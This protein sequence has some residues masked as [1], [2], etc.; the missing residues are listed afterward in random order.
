MKIIIMNI[1]QTAFFLRRNFPLLFFLIAVFCIEVK[2]SNLS[3]EKILLKLDSTSVNGQTSPN[4]N[5]SDQSIIFVLSSSD[6]ISVAFISK[7][8]SRTDIP[9]FIYDTPLGLDTT[10]QITGGNEDLLKLAV[11]KKVGKAGSKNLFRIITGPILNNMQEEKAYI[12]ITGENPEQI[13]NPRQIQGFLSGAAQKSSISSK[14]RMPGSEKINLNYTKNRVKIY[15]RK[16]GLYA[17]SG[18]DLEDKGWD[19]SRINRNYLRLYNLGREIPIEIIGSKKRGLQR[20]DK[21]VFFGEKLSDIDVTHYR[22]LT[23]YS[24]ENVYILELSDSPG[25]R[26]SQEEGMIKSSSGEPFSYPFTKKVYDKNSLI[27]LRNANFAKPEEHLVYSGAIN[28]GEK[29]ESSVTL[30]DPDIWST[31]YVKFKMMVRGD[32]VN[33]EEANPVDVYLGGRL[34]ASGEWTGANLSIIQSSDFSP[35][36]LDEEGK[37]SI[38]VI[39]RSSG[40]EFSPMYVD[41]FEITYPRLFKADENFLRFRAPEKYSGAFCNFTIENFSSPDIILFKKDISRIIGG[42]VKSVTDSLN[43]K[44]FTLSFEDSIVSPD[45]EYLA[46]TVRSLLMPDSIN[47]IQFPASFLANN[48]APNIIIVPVDSFLTDINRLVKYRDENGIKSAVVMLDD[49]YN[50]FG[51][52]IPGPEPIRL[53]LRWAYNV[54]NPKPVTVLL[55]GSGTFWGRKSQSEGNLIPVPIFH[56]IKFGACAADHFYSLLEGGDNKPDLGVAR[57]PVKTIENLKTIVDKTI[58]YGNVPAQQ[59]Q[60]SYCFIAA[61]GHGNIFLYQTEEFISKDISPDLS[62]VRLYLSSAKGASYVGTRDNLVSYINNG[63]FLLN[64]RGHGG[65]AVWSDG[66]TFVIEDMDLLHNKG[67]YPFVTSMTCFTAD[68]SSTREGLGE[69][70]LVSK[71]KGAVGFWGATGVGWI[72]NDYNLLTEF[73][74]VMRTEPDMYV[75]E[76]IKE[77]KRNFL[78]LYGGSIARSDAYQYTLLGDPCLKLAFP[79]EYADA[80]LEK[81]AV[82]D[83]VIIKGNSTGS[84][85]NVNIE[86][87][88]SDLQPVYKTDFTFMSNKWKTA[89]PVPDTLKSASE[90][91]GVRIWEKNAQ[92]D[93]GKHKYIPFSLSESYFDSL[94]TDP[95]I[96]NPGFKFRISIL[97]DSEE[98]IDSMWCRIT[99]P[100][101]DISLMQRTNSRRFVTDK[102]FGPYEPDSDIILNFYYVTDQK[103]KTESDVYKIHIPGMPDL[104]CRRVE[105]TG[106]DEVLLSAFIANTGASGVDSLVVK[107]ICPDLSFTSFDTISI[108]KDSFET[109][110]V[111]F[112]PVPGNLNISITVDPESEIGETNEENNNSDFKLIPSI[113]NV[114]NKSGTISGSVKDTVGVEGIGYCF[115]PP[116]SGIE[117]WCVRISKSTDPVLYQQNG[118]D[119]KFTKDTQC[120]GTVILPVSDD[121]KKPALYRW[122]EASKRWIICSGVVKKTKV[123]ATV[124]MP[125]S[126]S[127]REQSDD[128]PPGIEIQVQG[129][130][131]ASGS[132]VAENPT[133]TILVEDSSGVNI[134]PDKINIYLDDI[135]AN[136]S[137]IVIPD[138]VKNPRSL[139]VLYRPCLEDGEHYLVVTA[140]DVNG[141]EKKTEPVEL[142]VSSRFEIKYL[143]NHPNPFSPFKE[144]TIFAYILTGPAEKVSLKIFTVSG[145]LVKEFDDYL[146]HGADYH[147]IEW[148]G[149][150]MAGEKVANGVYFFSIEAESDK[151][152][153]VVR[154]K[155]AIIQ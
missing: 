30:P 68:F 111:P 141:N 72:F 142:L 32:A 20:D 90:T 12:E 115:I 45:A 75:G 146:M 23:M 152:K 136:K 101:A 51:Y 2:A 25:L 79:S 74:R 27:R 126:F 150:D 113:F 147:E 29:W 62:P 108:G 99:N 11:V 28:G 8:G 135:P 109:A 95:L 38:T 16:E 14:S 50:E 34:I 130:P 22:P 39:N 88:G 17:V 122:S 114:T 15:I 63:L 42:V 119:I 44:T 134:N 35:A 37:N 96:V 83:S 125:G 33:Q 43:N 106:T 84:Q 41:W 148:D 129:Q 73:L 105:L 155:I 53:F 92:S 58:E 124:S 153:E 7:S 117:N 9:A 97:A 107:F 24:L 85:S 71:D 13:I 154:G 110:E 112:S 131:F 94:E 47:S 133:I 69:S 91:G 81:R 54:W 104:S 26:F 144:K 1:K 118:V 66:G 100:S 137:E 77:A 31:L 78:T 46:A 121:Y 98:S 55:A 103:R 123:I 36:F 64:F 52:G 57:F 145:R 48:R 128:I 18:K 19:I 59:W 6:T 120:S 132:Y 21:I 49:I 151:G 138:S 143:G 3:S 140:E 67:K 127:V 5:I 89:I 93:N 76:M 87:T 139:T 40:G 116:E 60:N 102:Q 10:A 82:S 80:V 56:S 70:M 61:G 4:G 149:S 65:G 86:I